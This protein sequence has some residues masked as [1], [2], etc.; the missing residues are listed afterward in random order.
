MSQLLSLEPDA[1]AR[2]LQA[3]PKALLVLFSAQWCGPCK[4]YKPIVERVTAETDGAALLVVDCDTSTELATQFGIRA[5]PTLLC[6][7]DGELVA[8]QTGAMVEP[9]LRSLLRELLAAG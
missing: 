5:V 4:T 3:R 6:F 2:T 7:R 1:L 8:Q 9:Q